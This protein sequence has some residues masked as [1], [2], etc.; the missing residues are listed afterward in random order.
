[1]QTVQVEDMQFGD[2]ICVYVA[3]AEDDAFVGADRL[4]SY[5]DKAQRKKAR[6][7]ALSYARKLAREIKCEVVIDFCN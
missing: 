2:Y 1:M 5:E 7:E 4:Y 3:G 6:G